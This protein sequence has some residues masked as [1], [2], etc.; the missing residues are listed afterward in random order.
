MG[1]GT[2]RS[3]ELKSSPAAIR[4]QMARTRDR[5]RDDLKS[6]KDRLLGTGPSSSPGGSST[7]ATKKASKKSTSS[8]SGRSRSGG[9]KSGVKKAARV[10]AAKRSAKSSMK[11]SGGRKRSVASK[12]RKVATHA[13][14]GA[15]MGAVKGA[16]QAIVADMSGS[17]K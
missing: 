2:G 3:D 1:Q 4:K 10:S 14:E 5:L 9:K 11:K 15:A 16:A 7:M 8:K 6:L 12:T 13:L 17:S